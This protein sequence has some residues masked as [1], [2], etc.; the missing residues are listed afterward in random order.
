[1]WNRG[2]W[3]WCTIHR[4]KIWGIADVFQS[5]IIS[6]QNYLYLILLP[7]CMLITKKELYQ[8]IINEK[9]GEHFSGKIFWW[10]IRVL[11]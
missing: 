6:V 3:L 5:P 2:P 9:C 7:F 1:M 8:R 4:G 11:F 10:I